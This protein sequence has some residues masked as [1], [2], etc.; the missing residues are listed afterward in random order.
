MIHQRH[1]FERPLCF[2]QC[3]FLFVDN[4][5]LVEESILNQTSVEQDLEETTPRMVERVAEYFD[6][7]AEHYERNMQKAEYFSPAWIAKRAHDF[8]EI[9]ECRVLDLGCGTGINVKAL[10]GQRGGIRAE[11]VDVSPKM[12]AQAQATGRYER[13]YAHD[14]NT[15]LPSVPS[16]AFDL[17][18]AFG[19]LELL[20]DISVCLSE[21]CRV[22]KV[23]GTLWASFRCFEAGDE[24]S[25]PR[26][27]CVDGNDLRGYSAE[28]ILQMMRHLEMSV[29]S[30]DAVVGYITRSGFACPFY[31]LRARKS[32]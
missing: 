9:P 21:C 3:N 1:N 4:D 12:L 22:L 15:V 29:T 20:P 24:G 11:G 31:V 2:W 16:D 8:E 18:V 5:H 32:Q 14:L 26:H 7:A 27:M 25:P 6:G 28:E 10:F 30:L 17:V 23:N 19:F 13:L